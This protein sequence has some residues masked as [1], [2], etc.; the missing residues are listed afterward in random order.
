MGKD[1]DRERA[2]QE[3]LNAHRIFH[4]ETI[5]LVTTDILKTLSFSSEHYDYFEIIISL[6]ITVSLPH[7]FFFPSE[8]H[9]VNRLSSLLELPLRLSTIDLR[10]ISSSQK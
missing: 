8:H 1:W 10:Q 7:N 2:R 9:L 3:I 6:F 5:F 4:S